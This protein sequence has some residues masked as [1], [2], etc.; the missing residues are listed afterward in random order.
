M[1]GL[2]LALGSGLGRTGSGVSGGGYGPELVVNG[3]PFSSTGWTIPAAWTISGGTANGQVDA[4]DL[5]RA[6]DGTIVAANYLVQMTVDTIFEGTVRV[7]VGGAEGVERDAAGEYEETIAS[8]A[9]DQLVGLRNGT[10]DAVIS[11]LSVR[12][13]L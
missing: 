9:A 13:V 3:D 11:R 12:Q 4:G 1:T 10:S 8:L 6:A 2:S 7:L 5:T